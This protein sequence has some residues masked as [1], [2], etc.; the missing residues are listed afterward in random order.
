MH[1]I[2]ASK[3]PIKSPLTVDRQHSSSVGYICLSEVNFAKH[4]N[5]YL[6]KCVRASLIHRIGKS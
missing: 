5:R 3:H 6:A 1:E 4:L 2:Y